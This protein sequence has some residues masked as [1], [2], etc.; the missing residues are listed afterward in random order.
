MYGG[1][2]AFKN[3]LGQPSSWK[4]IC[5]FSLFYFVFEGNF[6]VQAPRGAYIWIGD[7]KINGGFLSYEFGELIFGG[8]YT[9]RGLY[10]EGLIFGI[11]RY[12]YSSPSTSSLLSNSPQK[13]IKSQYKRW[14]PALFINRFQNCTV[15]IY[16]FVSIL[17]KRSMLS[18]LSFDLYVT[19]EH[20]MTTFD[21]TRCGSLCLK[22]KL[23]RSASPTQAHRRL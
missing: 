23:A 17:A 20:K 19:R 14:R 21:S 12:I 11:V 3:P 16:F 13:Q 8:A 15:I 1:K 6:Q 10:V 4:E 9:W 7:F 18:F 5:R 22:K 2:I